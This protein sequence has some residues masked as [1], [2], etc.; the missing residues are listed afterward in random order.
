MAVM[1]S[2]VF[3]SAVILVLLVNEGSAIRCYECNSFNDTRCAQDIPPVELSVQ[4]G[5]GKDGGAST[6]CRKIVQQIEFSVNGLQP[7]VRIIRTCAH[8]NSDT[9]VKC[10]KRAGFG[11]RQVVCGCEGDNCNG[12]M[13][14]K[15]I[16]FGPIAIIAIL[17]YLFHL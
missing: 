11:G 1:Q 16:T 4:C 12:S 3:A 6:T 2:I 15:A 10:Y 8:D 17:A 14:L 7:D 13:S 5:I 9:K